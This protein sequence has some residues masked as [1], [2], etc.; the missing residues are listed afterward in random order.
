MFIL[1]G[2]LNPFRTKAP[3]IFIPKRKE[4]S[5][6]SS[7]WQHKFLYFYYKS[8]ERDVLCDKIKY[9]HLASLSN[10]KQLPICT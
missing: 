1:L 8:V 5:I 4:T 7:N 9:E 2:A 3:K 6:V 10:L